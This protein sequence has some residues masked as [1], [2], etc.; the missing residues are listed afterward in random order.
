[1]LD[2]RA[3][4]TP[5]E[6]SRRGWWTVAAAVLALAQTVLLVTTA[7]DKLDTMDEP[8]YLA[9]AVQLWW[10]PGSVETC[11]A[12]ALAKWGFALP[13]RLLEPEMFDPG[14]PSGR[15][16]LWSRPPDVARRNLLAARGATILV[17]VVGGLFLWLAARRF[18]PQVALLAHALW[19]FSPAVLA[20]GS[21]AALDAWLT[22]LL[23]V[24][25]WATF[26]VAERPSIA[27]LS[28]LGFTLALAA[29]AKAP[30]LGFLPV[31]VC[32][33]WWSTVRHAGGRRAAAKGILVAATVVSLVFLS[34]LAGVY[35]FRLGTLDI[36]DPCGLADTPVGPTL[37]PVPFAPWLASLVVQ[38][39]HGRGGHYSYLFGETSGTGW[40]WFY[41][42][43]L[44]LKTTLAAQ[45]LAI[46][47]LAAWLKRPPNRSVLAIDAAILVYPMLVIAVMSLGNTQNGLRYILPAFPFLMLVGAR[48]LPDLRAAFGRKG[49]AVASAVLL[50]GMLEMLSV[51]PHHLMFFNFW[52]G[53][54]KGGPRYLINGDDWGQDQRRVALWQ[55]ENRPGRFFYTRY[56]VN[57][58]HWGITFEAPPCEPKQGFYALHAV[59]V[60]RPKRIPAGCLDW[61]TVDEPDARFGY[62]IYF[63]VVNGER[64]AQ[65]R[66]PATKKPFWSSAGT[67]RGG[68]SDEEEKNEH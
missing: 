64:A 54:P 65:L 62:S 50:V 39:Q 25:G 15:H 56:T 44:A 2:S 66:Q 29:A 5:P 67:S 46:L 27:R 6:Q 36:G 13:L 4:T 16:P 8:H 30:G 18:G 49:V 12:P 21:L 10:D 58:S 63:Y 52:A 19:C 17:T 55:R 1:M 47:R 60:H 28:T 22:S 24:A 33:A 38:T 23:C 3:M 68:S 43:A 53:G 41:L 45:A 37:G 14:A 51:H 48:A 40:W 11:D 9:G 32:V 7:L 57:P 34:T 20:Q 26:R 31:A 35:G 42:A 59:E 61:L